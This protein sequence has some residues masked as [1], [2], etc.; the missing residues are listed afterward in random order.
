MTASAHFQV[1]ALAGYATVSIHQRVGGNRCIPVTSLLLDPPALTHLIGQLQ[2]ALDQPV[3]EPSRSAPVV[4]VR[5]DPVGL[6]TFTCRHHPDDP[7]RRAFYSAA[8][9]IRAAHKHA[10]RH[11]QGVQS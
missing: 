10:T 8:H 6:W 4:T 3:A 2:A 5:K 9:A 1:T 11:T 7:I